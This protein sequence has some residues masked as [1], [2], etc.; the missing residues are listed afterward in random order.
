MV[1]DEIRAVLEAK[2]D[3]LVRRA[4]GDLAALIDPGFVYVNA[5]GSTFDKAGYVETFCGPGGVVFSEQRF[6]DLEFRPFAGFAVATM[7]V[8]DTFTAGGKAVA[9][10]YRSLCVFGKTGD[11]WLWSAGQTMEV[12]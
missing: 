4:V 10:T 12:R 8:N 9:A 3:A 2:A 7:T 1:A 5:R 6:S 11:R